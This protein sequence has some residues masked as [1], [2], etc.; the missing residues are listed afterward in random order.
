MIQTNKVNYPNKNYLK[1]KKS[2]KQRVFSRQDTAVARLSQEKVL[3]E[4]ECLQRRQIQLITFLIYLKARQSII[5]T[6]SKGPNL[7]ALA[8]CRDNGNLTSS[9]TEQWAQRSEL[10][11]NHSWQLSTEQL[12]TT[13]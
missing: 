9:Q 10:R 3:G 2:I 4:L 13:E 1:E 5:L 12:Q 8:S 11:G 7:T 6:S